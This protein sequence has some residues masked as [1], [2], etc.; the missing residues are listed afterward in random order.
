MVIPLTFR[1]EEFHISPTTKHTIPLS[2]MSVLKATTSKT[3]FQH[4]HV[5]PV[6]SG[7]HKTLDVVSFMKLFMLFSMRNKGF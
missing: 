1:M 4:G 3:I 6:G 2:R 7:Q 5:L